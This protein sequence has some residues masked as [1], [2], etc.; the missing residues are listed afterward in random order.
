MCS[1]SEQGGSSDYRP[2]RHMWVLRT[3]STP[4]LLNVS[5]MLCF[6]GLMGRSI[7]DGIPLEQNAYLNLSQMVLLCC[8]IRRCLTSE[9]S[10]LHLVEAHAS[11]VF[12]LLG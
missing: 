4:L 2:G 3:L 11:L 6:D 7:F 8:S 12:W 5:G 9:K 1:T 10:A